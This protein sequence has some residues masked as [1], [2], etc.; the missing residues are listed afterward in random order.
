MRLVSACFCIACCDVS[1]SELRSL[2]ASTKNTAS[3]AP[4]NRSHPWRGFYQ[5]NDIHNVKRRRRNRAK[6]YNVEDY[7]VFRPSIFFLEIISAHFIN[8]SCPDGV[9][10]LIQSK[11]C[12]AKRVIFFILSKIKCPIL[13]KNKNIRWNIAE[14]LLCL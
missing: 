7:I 13:L 12:Y 14:N 6:E 11:K 9:V 4:H 10:F 3:T 1:L 5:V 8:H 2:L